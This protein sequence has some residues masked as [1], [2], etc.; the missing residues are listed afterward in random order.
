MSA[1]GP[2]YGARVREL[3]ETQGD[4]LAIVFS[5]DHGPEQAI[6]WRQ[7]DDRSTQVGR[8]LAGLGLAAGDWLAIQLPNSLEH[9]LATFG[10]WK[11]GATVVPI[12]WDV[13]D[14]ERDR[15]LA[16]IQPRVVL[17]A[18]VM[19]LFDHSR[20]MPA[21]P[22]P[23]VTPPRAW[24]ICSSGSTGT[25]KVIVRDVPGVWDRTSLKLVEPDGSGSVPPLTL[26]PAPLYHTNGFGA[27]MTLL[28]GEPIILM[29][30]FNAERVLDL[31]E[32]HRV[33]SFIAATPMLHRI[34]KVPGVT[35]RDLSS[36]QWVMQGASPIPQWLAR[37]WC[38]LIGPER[39]YFGYGSAENVG[40][41]TCRGDEWLEHPGTLG[42]GWADTEIRILAPDRSDLPPGEVGE[43]FMR[44]SARGKVGAYR[45]DAPPIPMTAD[46]FATIGDLGW[47]DEQGYLYLADRRVDMIV[48]GGANVYPA[49]VEAALSEHPGVDDVVVIGLPDPDWG[50]RVHALIQPTDSVNPVTPEEIV[51]FAKT[52]LSS[53][54]V[55]KTVELVDKIP[56]NEATKVN[57]TALVEARVQAAGR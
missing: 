20:T 3:A 6:S 18:T 1:M 39:L 19:S 44:S 38:D 15:L 33:T 24:G 30:R 23:D 41:V 25:P 57:R 35:G 50:K 36:L 52:R 51:A 29:Q 10:G 28:A 42:R 26:V 5:A 13:P 12:R 22:L 14:W 37:F 2:S 47:L 49:E 54:K 8:A 40:V 21:H 31:I 55:P 45:G 43:I 53:Y 16:V 9:L 4:D 7:L 17:D 11:V 32:R 46:G 48:S 56:R 34:A 27:T